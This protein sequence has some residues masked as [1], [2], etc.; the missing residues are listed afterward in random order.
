MK[1]IL[2][3]ILFALLGATSFAAPRAV[4]RASLVLYPNGKYALPDGETVVV[5]GSKTS[6]LQ[7]AIDRAAKDGFDLHVAGGDYKSK[8]YHCSTSVVLPP[9][10]GKVISFGSATIN[11][12]GFTDLC[13]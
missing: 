10:Q 5:K 12:D 9:M 11:F 6:G 3:I 4:E 1:H 8:V 2:L 7:E 13:I